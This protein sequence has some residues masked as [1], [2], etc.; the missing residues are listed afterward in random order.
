ME[1]RFTRTVQA[2]NTDT[3]NIRLVHSHITNI[4]YDVVGV[5]P[6]IAPAHTYDENGKTQD[7]VQFCGAEWRSVLSCGVGR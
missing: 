5:I 6:F 2:R 1:N 4:I 7:T 3:H